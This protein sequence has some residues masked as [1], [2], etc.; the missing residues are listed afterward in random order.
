MKTTEILMANTTGELN[1]TGEK[2]RAA[3]WYGTKSGFHSIQ[4]SVSEFKGN[5]G[6]QGTLAE[7]PQEEDW[8]DVYLNGYEP[9]LKY[10]CTETSTKAFNIVGN[11]IWLRAVMHRD[12][13]GYE[14]SRD[15]ISALGIVSRIILSR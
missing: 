15:Q 3:G 8:F 11:F 2:K 5:I 4:I 12:D 6:I 14:P 10:E 9:Y 13:I 1:V 7:D